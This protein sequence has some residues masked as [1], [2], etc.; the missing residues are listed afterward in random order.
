MSFLDKFNN[1]LGDITHNIDRSLALQSATAELLRHLSAERRA[2]DTALKVSQQALDLEKEL[3]ARG[4]EFRARFE[5]SY[6][7]L[8]GVQA[9]EPQAEA[10][11]IQRHPLP[12]FE[13]VGSHHHPEI[14]RAIAAKVEGLREDREAFLSTA[15]AQLASDPALY[16]QFQENLAKVDGEH[17]WA[18]L[19][20]RGTLKRRT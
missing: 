12:N 10:A 11:P 4:P 2:I 3:A 18:T 20:P 14:Q 15:Y 6:A 9:A 1:A 19:A 17:Y 13:R 16:A 5:Q 7:E 8:L